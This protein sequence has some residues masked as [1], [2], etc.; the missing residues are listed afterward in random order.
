M[1][2]INLLIILAT[3]NNAYNAI[4]PYNNNVKFVN[5]DVLINDSTII[6]VNLTLEFNNDRN[7]NVSNTYQRNERFKRHFNNNYKMFPTIDDAIEA[8]RQDLI[9]KERWIGGIIESPQ[10]IYRYFNIKYTTCEIVI[11]CEYFSKYLEKKLRIYCRENNPSYSSTNT[12]SYNN[13]REYMYERQNQF[14]RNIQTLNIHDYT[15][16]LHMDIQ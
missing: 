3:I 10:V 11:R 4:I 12:E 16:T 14:I 8:F 7:K 15:Q 2:I 5:F 9:L 1:K 6:N 13:P